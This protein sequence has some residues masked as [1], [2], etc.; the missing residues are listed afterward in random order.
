[1]EL[2]KSLDKGYKVLKVFEA[3]H[4][5]AVN[6]YEW[7]SNL[8]GGLFTSYVNT[9]IKM[10][11]VEGWPTHCNND[12]SRQAYLSDIEE[13]EGIMQD[14]TE[15]EKKSRRMGFSKADAKFVLGQIWSTK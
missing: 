6:R 14:R 12:A 3:W 13:P 1:M 5:N 9:F 7:I 8:Y 15:I 2:Y 4:Y 10:K 11:M